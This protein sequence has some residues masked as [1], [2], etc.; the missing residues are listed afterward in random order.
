MSFEDE[1]SSK[2]IYDGKAGAPIEAITETQN[3]ILYLKNYTTFRLNEKFESETFAH[4]PYNTTTMRN[5]SAG[6][7]YGDQKG[8]IYRMDERGC[9][10][11]KQPMLNAGGWITAIGDTSKG[12]LYASERSRPKHSFHLE[13]RSEIYSLDN[14]EK[15]MLEVE[16]WV[17]D[18]T[19]V[20]TSKLQ[21]TGVI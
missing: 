21:E 19:E 10:R 11:Q 5:T 15:P 6:V 20:S 13:L 8:N 12:V 4:F 3:D 9:Q 16:G 17:D 2:R 7:L 18:I 14:P 1:V